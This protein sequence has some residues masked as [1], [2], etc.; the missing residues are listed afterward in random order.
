[1]GRSTLLFVSVLVLVLVVVACGGDDDSPNRVL[2]LGNGPITERDFRTGIRTVDRGEVLH[3][4][5]L[6][7]FTYFHEY[8]DAASENAV[9]FAVELI[10]GNA[11]A[12]AEAV[13]ADMERAAEIVREECAGWKNI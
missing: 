6:C 10:S 5:T 12:I 8:E 2:K 3:M 9:A 13:P 7:E 4:G 1:M 11:P